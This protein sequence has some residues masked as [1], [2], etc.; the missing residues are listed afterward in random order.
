M[1]NEISI[2]KQQ[3]GTL[4]VG[5]SRD[6]TPCPSRSLCTKAKKDPR[7]LSLRPKEE[8]L[9][10]QTARKF[11]QTDAFKEEYAKRAGIEGTISQATRAFGLRQ[12][13]YLGLAKTHLQHLLTA[14]AINLVRFDAWQNGVP[15]AK[16]RLS[17]FAALAVVC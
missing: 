8:H 10:L 3:A 9:A 13:R 17:P 1:E 12:A 11:Q 6:C 16:T 7:E 5:E 14:G 4:N 15:H 2:H